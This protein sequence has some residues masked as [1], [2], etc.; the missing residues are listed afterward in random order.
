[1]VIDFSL[2][3]PNTGIPI[4]STEDQLFIVLESDIAVGVFYNAF[5]KKIIAKYRDTN[6]EPQPVHPIPSR[7][8]FDFGQSKMLIIGLSWNLVTDAV[9]M[10]F[11]LDDGENLN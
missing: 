7:A 1:M 5:T 8:E 2:F 9:Y 4:E 3:L 6:N 10:S 11:D